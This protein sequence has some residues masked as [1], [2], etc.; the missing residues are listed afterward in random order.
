MATRNTPTILGNLE[1]ADIKTSL[2]EYLRNQSVFAGY[3]FEGSAIQTLISLLAYN[4]FYYAYYANMVN[5]EAFLDSAQLE[6]SV[7]SLTKPLGYTVPGRKSATANI[8]VTGLSG[9]VIPKGTP[10]VAANANGEFFSFYN[11]EDIQIPE[12][13]VT[14]SFTI[15][16]ASTF[17]NEVDLLPTFDTDNQKIAI[18]NR[19][20]DLSTVS[21]K[22]KEAGVDTLYTWTPVSNIGYASQVDERI[23][24]IERT[25]NGF[26]INFGVQNSL[27]KGIDESVENLY[28]TYLT[29]NGSEGNGLLNF[30]VTGLAGNPIVVVNSQSSGGESDPDLDKV[31]FLA[32][33]WFSS[34]ERAVT[35]NDY[36]ALLLDAGYFTDEAEFSVFGGQDLVPPRYGRVFVSSSVTNTSII[37]EMIGFLKER[38]VIT[39][40]P[41]HVTSNPLNIFVDIKFRT[42]GQ[43]LVPRSN[44]VT[45]VRNQ[46]IEGEFAKTNQYNVNFDSS[47]FINYLQSKDEINNSLILTLSDF[48]IYVYENIV[49]NKEYTFNIGN[50]FKLPTYQYVDV[51]EPFTPDTSIT[52]PTGFTQ[53]VLRMYTQSLN[54]KNNRLNLQLWAINPDTGAE[55]RIEKD[56]GY[57]I[58]NSGVIVIN[59]GVIGD[60]AVLNIEF[61]SKS[62]SV[63]LNNLVTL[64][65][66]NITL[67]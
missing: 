20:A 54:A 50:A 28:V 60:V 58:A 31:R 19:T 49:A 17:I 7:I 25:S 63:G 34:Q 33:K 51:T 11:L 12:S 52:L 23:F 36:K 59:S 10:F 1:Y 66:N 41:E 64:A 48:K 45:F 38:S 22:T 56:V 53:C 18:A 65:T 14:E 46:F 55:Q 5:A 21:I 16:E 29:S 26:V 62:I 27:G 3:N 30:T 2:T 37:N 4:T 57:Y 6:E 61:D 47:E 43:Q 39:V 67:L 40:L 24:F 15:Y 32:P 44:L 9:S 35:T 8:T 13:G 42:N